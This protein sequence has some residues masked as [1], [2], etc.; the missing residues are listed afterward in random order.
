[1]WLLL[2]YLALQ[3]D[4]AA[5]VQSHKV[6]V[7]DEKSIPCDDRRPRTVR[8]MMGRVTVLNFPF[9]PKD[10]VPGSQAFD[11]KQIKNDLVITSVHAAGH[12]NAVVYLEERRCV[13][14][15]VSVKS[16]GDD[17][18]VVKDPKDSQYEVKF[19]E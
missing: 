15:L 1:M 10:V 16:G 11:F 19:H 4:Q 12:T 5:A 2:F 9:K 6:S 14:D 3:A 18:L 7:S 8:V 17:I 13:F